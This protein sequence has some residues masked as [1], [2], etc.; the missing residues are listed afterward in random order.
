[1]SFFAAEPK[2][3]ADEI[4]EGSSSS[5]A[6]APAKRTKAHT[7]PPGYTRE[8]ALRDIRKDWSIVKMARQKDKPYEPFLH[9]KEFVKQIVGLSGSI[10]K[11]LPAEMRDDEDVVEH[12]ILALGEDMPAINGLGMHMSAIQW[13]SD[14]LKHN[15]EFIKTICEWLTVGEGDSA[16]NKKHLFRYLPIDIVKQVEPVTPYLLEYSVEHLDD[17]LFQSQITILPKNRGTL[18]KKLFNMDRNTSKVNMFKKLVE[19]PDGEYTL[20][21]NIPDTVEASG[22]KKK[23]EFEKHFCDF[24]V[25]E[26]VDLETYTNIMSR[27]RGMGTLTVSMSTSAA[28][29]SV[30]FGTNSGTSQNDFFGTLMKKLTHIT[31]GNVNLMTTLIR[32]F[33][34]KVKKFS[35]TRRLNFSNVGLSLQPDPDSIVQHLLSS[36][37][38]AMG[39][40]D[41][42]LTAVQEQYVGTLERLLTGSNYARQYLNKLHQVEGKPATL[43]WIA[44][45]S[46]NLEMVRVL[47]SHGAN[48]NDNRSYRGRTALMLAPNVDIVKALFDFARFDS[49]TATERARPAVNQSDSKHCTA[50]YHATS[51]N[52]TEVVRE[53]LR[54]GASPNI[55]NVHRRTPI[56]KAVKNLNTECVRMLLDPRHR[57]DVNFKDYNGNTIL[58]Y[59]AMHRAHT[60]ALGY[61]QQ[62]F[63]LIT[64]R[65]ADLNILNPAEQ[66]P[67]AVCSGVI[68]RKLL[69]DSGA[70]AKIDIKTFRRF[71]SDSFN[72]SPVVLQNKRD[73]IN[74]EDHIEAPVRCTGIAPSMCRHVFSGPYIHHWFNTRYRGNPKE[75]CPICRQKIYYVEILSTTKAQEWDSLEKQALDEEKR[76]EGQIKALNEAPRYRQ[77]VA[78]VEQAKQKLKEAEQQL[79]PVEDE[80]REIRAA[81]DAKQ[82]ELRSKQIIKEMENL[83]F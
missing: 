7:V 33:M 59:L 37:D 19:G 43:L 24:M 39:V 5:A 49:S 31:Y 2:R 10:L 16:S 81:S 78:E 1:M 45:T 26:D 80:M 50:L 82:S 72:S 57:V 8:E 69:I 25:K 6:P 11:Y 36:V 60:T 75:E 54:R 3:K 18:L 53:L 56:F 66:T 62:I 73:D 42:L 23:K 70:G 41:L 17:D 27:L 4:S 40:E 76:M 58:H 71:D 64:A 22:Y 13:A 79:G 52:R 12:A 83:K 32:N 29:Y 48:V 21:K 38:F 15:V 61:V 46:A 77:L 74:L 63:R 34:K 30:R 68:L 14:R 28:A 51:H 9:D 47:L 44:V 35:V 65:G 55:V 20:R 67:L